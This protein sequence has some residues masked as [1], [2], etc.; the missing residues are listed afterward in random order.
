MEIA[1]SYCGIVKGEMLDKETKF[2]FQEQLEE[3]YGCVKEFS[4]F[5]LI[6]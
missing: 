3:N 5:Q 2:E 6:K 4:G 1:N